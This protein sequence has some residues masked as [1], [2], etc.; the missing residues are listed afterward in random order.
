MVILIF[1]ILKID[2]IAIGS[3]SDTKI[4]IREKTDRDLGVGS[5]SVFFRIA[6]LGSDRDPEKFW[7]AI[8]I[9]S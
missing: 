4:A 5:R 1:N 3:R 8:A 6:I 7:I 9:R 2:P